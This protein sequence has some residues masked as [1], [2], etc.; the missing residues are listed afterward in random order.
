MTVAEIKQAKA[1]DLVMER[2]ASFGTVVDVPTQTKQREA[3]YDMRTVTPQRTRELLEIIVPEA[4]VFERT[5]IVGG[6]ATEETPAEVETL[7]HG[8]VSALDILLEITA[9]L[10]SKAKEEGFADAARVVMS[11]Q[12]IEIS[13]RETAL[14]GVE[15]DKIKALG[16]YDVVI[17]IKQVEPIRRKVR[18]VASRQK[19]DDSV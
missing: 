3:R 9:Q 6:L 7:I 16:E 15:G 10:A 1:A 13:S 12:D 14:D 11:A 2:D 18:V 19:T 8:S 4:L 17:N 5:P